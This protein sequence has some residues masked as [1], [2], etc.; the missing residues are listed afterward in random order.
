MSCLNSQLERDCLQVRKDRFE[1]RLSLDWAFG[2]FLFFL[3][4]LGMRL[5]DCGYC[6]MN[7]NRKVWLFYFF[8]QLVH[9]VY[10]LWT[11]KFHFSATFSL[12]IGT[13]VLFT[14][15]KII[16]LQYFSVFSFSFQFSVSVFS[17]IQTDP[18]QMR[19][20]YHFELKMSF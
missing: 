14:H 13:T 19:G 10:C 11:H 5:W 20:L 12:K 15:L 17:C 9:I 16:L 6:L 18:K 7:S 2:L 4:F 3:F 1:L 8:S